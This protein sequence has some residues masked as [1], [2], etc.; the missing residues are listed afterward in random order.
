MRITTITKYKNLREKLQT[1]EK[2]QALRE[3]NSLCNKF[4]Q[5]HNFSLKT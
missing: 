2:L 4:I 1:G 5:S 3:K